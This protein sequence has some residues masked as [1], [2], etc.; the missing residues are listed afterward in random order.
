MLKNKNQ[1]ERK[2]RF[3]SL[4]IGMLYDNYGAEFYY[5]CDLCIWLSTLSYYFKGC[6]WIRILV[7]Y[8]EIFF[9]VFL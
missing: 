6:M 5:Y 9:P 7:Q 8:R 4:E 3:F 1:I 2:K